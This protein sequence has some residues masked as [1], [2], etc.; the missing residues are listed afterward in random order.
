MIHKIKLLIAFFIVSQFSFS[1][2]GIDVYSDYLS[3]NYYLIHPSMAGAANCAKLRITGRKQ[4]FGQVDAPSLQTASFNGR[5]SE[6]SGAG[7]ILFNDINGYHSQ[8]GL[9]LTYAHHLMFSRDNIDLNQLSFGISA[10]FIQS[11]LD[12]TKFLQ[13]GDYDP[14]ING[15]IVQKASY[16]NLDIGAS[17][18]Y[19]DFYVHGTIKNAI[20][21][22][23]NIYT[24]YESDNLRKLL[25]SAGYIF[26]D[27]ERILW[28]PSVLFQYVDVTGEKGIDLNI[29]AYKSFDFGK[30]W[31]VLSYRRSFDGAE[32]L[33]GN[34]V[35]SQKLQYITPI[36]GLN[37][38]KYMFAYT[39]SYLT[40][41]IN[42]TTAGF[43][44]ITLG[45]DLF[46]SKEK[47]ECY[48]PAIN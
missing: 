37:Y 47:Y 27:R 19:L 10:D 40:G 14:I 35:S 46:C 43:H 42:F 32:Y 25:L 48:C 16:F 6:K 29:K 21:T 4:W 31:A 39:Y 13:S 24:E 26:G 41:P 22:R 38:D 28:E 20:E 18:N 2:E 23:R 9:K 12:E 11:Q 36:I 5:I 44:Q 15:T 33:S 8:S 7:I 45:I 34:Q 30:L 1:Q 17:Y 3:D